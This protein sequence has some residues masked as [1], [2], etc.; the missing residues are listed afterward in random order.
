MKKTVNKPKNED[1]E[2]V[3]NVVD[4]PA[5]V[6]ADHVRDR[7]LK[8]TAGAKA[9]WSRLTVEFRAEVDR[10]LRLRVGTGV[11][12]IPDPIYNPSMPRSFWGQ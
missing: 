1:D 2:S 9:G 5:V 4:G 7:L 8:A 12:A 3:D 10:R 11:R 6:G